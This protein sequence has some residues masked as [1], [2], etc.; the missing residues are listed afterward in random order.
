MAAR[1]AKAA[2]E[3]DAGLA[4]DLNT[5]RALAAAFD[6]VR[7]ANIAVDKGEFRQGD[8]AAVLEF[9]ATFDRVFVVVED[10]DAEKLRTLGYGSAESG[11]GD[12]EIDR[13][14]AERNDAKK[15]RDFAA[16]DRIRKE[17]ADRGIMV[18]DAKDGSVRWK[19]K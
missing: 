18:E 7:E 3:F 5:A 10:N 6:L 14:V 12:I 9:L 4:D 17:L 15:K 19:R 13:L 1:I 2:E 11:P 8:V 16:A